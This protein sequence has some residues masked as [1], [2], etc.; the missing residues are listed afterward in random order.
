[1]DV[2]P[3]VAEGLGDSSYLVV[4]GDEAAVIDP[5]R[6]I[7]RIVAAAEARGARIRSV[8][9]THVH[10]DYVSGAL[11]L[12]S[13]TGAQVA[14]PAGAAYAFPFTPIQE[15]AEIS[16]GDLRLVALATPGHTPEHTAYQAFEPGSDGGPLALF[17]G[18]SLIVG[19]A[20]RTDLLGPELT[21]E[22]TRA[23]FRTMRRLAGLPDETLLLPTHG[24]GSFCASTRPDRERTSTI[25]A[26]RARNPAL[27]QTDEASF[28]RE[29]LDDLQAYPTYYAHMAPINRSGPRVFGDVPT[30]PALPPE[31]FA[32][33][34][35]GGAW[36]I[37]ARA[38]HDF[39]E[40]HISGSLNVPLEDSFASYVGWLV[41]FGTP[42][43]LVLP[44][45][46]AEA[47]PQAATRLFRIGYELIDGRLEGGVGAWAASGRPLGSYP[48][49]S[50]EEYADAASLGVQIALDV[51]QNREWSAGHI[52]GSVHL[53]VG[54]L[55][56][57][58]HELPREADVVVACATGFR[59]SI[60]A[61]VLARDGRRA[62]L[63]A[64]GGVPAAL[65]STA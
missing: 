59:A 49:A 42:V 29:Q 19:S 13:A 10:N 31:A 3:F 33:R 58:M 38:G 7:G 45:P 34:I 44:E 1:M 37:D 48:T 57:R 41:P 8:L 35:A 30:P 55:A 2:E 36:V 4:S 56:R 64:E 50:L 40:G 27:A 61:S 47:L 52:P 53:F 60:A 39:A 5:Q 14:G 6:D 12:R 51:R 23:Q 46:E 28:A 22:L 43:V 62:R 17:S 63:V 24:A 54:D 26:E 65:R 15:G 20:G 21:E 9:E 25:G 32:A 16:V 11:E 18:G